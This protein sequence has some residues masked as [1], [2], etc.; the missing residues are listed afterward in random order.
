MLLWMIIPWIGFVLL[1]FIFLFVLMQKT[2]WFSFK[3]F[4]FTIIS[5]VGIIGMTVAFGIAGYSILKSIIITDQEY[6]QWRNSREIKECE[7]TWWAIDDLRAY[8]LQEKTI[9]G[10]APLPQPNSP[11]Q[12][13]ITRCKNEATERLSKQRS[14]ETK[15]TVIWGLVRWI[16][17]LIL[18]TTHYSHMIRSKVDTE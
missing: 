3:K 14:F 6:I 1:I 11:S 9:D 13:D 4:Y 18:F 2:P 17:F 12:E 7:R 10:V 8:P 15:E 5:I 16:I